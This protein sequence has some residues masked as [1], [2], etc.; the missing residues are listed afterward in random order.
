[1]ASGLVS[2][3]FFQNG[4]TLPLHIR[5]TGHSLVEFGTLMSIQALALTALVLP[6][7]RLAGRLRTSTALTLGAALVG[8]GFVLTGLSSSYAVLAGC[9]FAWALGEVLWSPVAQAQTA[10]LAPAGFEARYQGALGPTGASGLSLSP[11]IG[12]ALYGWRP[13]SLWLACG[14]LAVLAMAAVEATSPG[15]RRL[16]IQG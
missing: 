7:T 2:F 4:S 9:V 5:D 1:L 13:E 8:G 12:T 16:R 3:V 6:V 15:G 10:D 14:V 11:L